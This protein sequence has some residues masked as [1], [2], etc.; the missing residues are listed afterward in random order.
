M[1]RTILSILVSSFF[2]LGQEE[3]WGAEQEKL[4]HFPFVELQLWQFVCVCVCT[5]ACVFWSWIYQLQEEL[6]EYHPLEPQILYNPLYSYI[7]NIFLKHWEYLLFVNLSFEC[8]SIGARNGYRHLRKGIN[9]TIWM[10]YYWRQLLSDYYWKM[11]Q[12]AVIIWLL[13]ENGTLVVHGTWWQNSYL[14]FILW[15]SGIKSPLR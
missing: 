2:L 10:A 11:G 15:S 12:K 3:S 6:I 13:L 9:M 8:H 4:F 1:A 14:N 7:N 5:H